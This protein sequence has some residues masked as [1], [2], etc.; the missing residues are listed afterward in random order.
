MGGSSMIWTYWPSILADGGLPAFRRCHPP[1]FFF[2]LVPLLTLTTGR[3]GAGAA[4]GEARGQLPAV[5]HQLG[6]HV[7]VGRP[8][9]PAA[10][11]PA[12]CWAIFGGAAAHPGHVG[13]PG[14]LGM[15]PEAIPFIIFCICLNRSSSVLTSLVEVPVPRAI[16]RGGSR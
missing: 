1:T 8:G 3:D 7:E 10:G 12:A 5:P 11:A 6:Q 16:R 2:F 13:H 9:C 4:G 14:R 15:L